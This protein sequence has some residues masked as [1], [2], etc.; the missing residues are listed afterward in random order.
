M[1]I[2]YDQDID[3]SPYLAKKVAIIGYGS[4]GH[5][6]A[7]NLKESGV[8]VI[9]AQRPGGKNYDLAREDGFSP[10]SVEDATQEADIIHV[11]LPDEIQKDV[12]AKSIHPF[13]KPGKA[14]VFSH[15][16]NIHFGFINPAKDIDV[17]MVAPKGPG[18]TVRREYKNGSGVPCLIAIHNDASGQSRELALAHAKGIGGARVG[19]LETSFKEET[20]TDLFGEQSVLCGGL[21]HL[22][23]AG[24]E[25]LVE[26]GYSK[27]MA[28]FEC[29][30]EMKLIVDLIYEGGIHNMRYSI[31]ETAEFGDYETGPKIITAE[32]K[33]TM[34]E[35]LKN[36]QNGNFARKFI[37]EA[38]NGKPTMK[39]IRKKMEHHDIEKVGAEL[40]KMMHSLFKQKAVR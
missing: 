13:L 39:A 19:V 2:Y 23:L 30:H 40:R 26:A 11:L 8:D 28:Y 25:T 20:E 29:L 4:Q 16:F 33:A 7:L 18:H 15:G 5:A 6:H 14:L 32:T 9:V 3:L 22:I 31:S 34:K 37:A 1:K 10:Y 17:Y 12:Y 38:E 36:I 35:V 24:F 21:V 27:E